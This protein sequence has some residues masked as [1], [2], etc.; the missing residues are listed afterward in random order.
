MP[1]TSELIGIKAI[2]LAR[3]SGL[4]REQFKGSIYWIRR[5]MRRKGFALHQRTSICQKLPEAYKDKLVEFQ[6]YVRL[7]QQHG[8]TLGQIGNANET[9][10]WFDMPSSTTVCERGVKAVKLL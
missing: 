10:V 3:E 6:R 1:V 9:P 8:Y 2:K 4:M 5:F 7:R